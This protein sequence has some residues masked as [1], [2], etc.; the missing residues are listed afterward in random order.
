MVIWKTTTQP[1]KALEG[2]PS[3]VR[4]LKASLTAVKNVRKAQLVFGEATEC[5][6]DDRL[7]EM[8]G[9]S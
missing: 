7:W 1:R 9:L 3:D 8:R 4:S 2:R 5:A 6:A